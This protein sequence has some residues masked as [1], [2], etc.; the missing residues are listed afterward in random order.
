MIGYNLA[1]GEGSFEI[2]RP[3]SRRW[4]NFGRS[5]TSEAGGGRVV[6][7]NWIIFMDI[8][9]VS[10]LKYDEIKDLRISIDLQA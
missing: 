3:R 8:I 10:S 2:G 9:C 7:E 6:L 5:W 1:V 4:K